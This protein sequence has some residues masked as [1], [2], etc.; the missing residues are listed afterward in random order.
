MINN[1][2]NIEQ[3]IQWKLNSGKS[4]ALWDNWLGEGQ[5]AQFSTNNQ[6]FDNRK[7]ADSWVND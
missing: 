4:S 6:M 1:R 2:N 5:R 3:H 7:V